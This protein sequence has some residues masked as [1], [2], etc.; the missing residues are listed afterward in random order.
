MTVGTPFSWS[1]LMVALISAIGASSLP[2]DDSRGAK[3]YAEKCAS[4]HGAEGEGV[5][6]KYAQPLIG[7]RSLAELTEYVAETMPEDKPGTCTGEDAQQVSAYL[8]DAFYSPIAQARNRPA[9]IDLSR[10]TVRQHRLA[11]AD[12]IGSFRW[13]AKQDERHGL[14][15][16]YYKA[17]RF[18]KENRII[19]RIDPQVRFD[20]GDKSPEEGKIEPHEFS[21]RWNGTIT[22]PE[23]GQYEIIVR[24]EHA[25]RL[26]LNDMKE[27]IVD[28]W[29]KSGND[30][31]Y[32]ASLFLLGGRMYPIRLEF[33]KAKQGVDDSDKD[34][35]PKLVPASVALLWKRPKM[36][37]EVIASR[38]LAPGNAPESF[39]L[40]T[41]FPPDDRSAGYERAASVSREWDQATTEAA[42]E[43]ANY[44]V[45]HI[46][47]FSATK[48]DSGD[49]DVKLKE[50][51]AKFA[52][53]AFRRPL[54]D[55]ERKLY[56]DQI[57]SEAGNP[58]LGVR[59]VVL[60]TMKSPRFLFREVE[61]HGDSWDV[62]SR[63]SFALWDSI[64]DQQLREVA[65][66]DQLKDE[67]QI[68][69]QAE[70]MV[71]DPRANAKLTEFFLRWLKVEQHPDL[72]KDAE[73]YVGFNAE[74]ACDLRSSLEI[75]LAD[76]LANEN[77]DLRELLKTHD[78][79]FNGR[80]AKFYGADL[81]EDA[82]FQRVSLQADDGAGIL[83]HPYLMAG[84]AYTA[85]SSPIHRGVFVARSLLGRSLRPPPEAVA[86][87]APDLHAGLT[88]RERVTL[89]TSP[90]A[91]QTCH[92]LINPLGFSFEHFDAVGRYRKEENGK[93]IDAKGTYRARSGDPIPMD[94]ANG[95]S[96][97]LAGSDEV[98]T[99]FVDQLFQYAV[100]QPIR[101][102]GS[103]TRNGLKANF[104]ENNLN[105]RKLFVQIAAAAAV[106]A[107][108]PKADASNPK[109]T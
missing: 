85:T 2:A 96:A 97:F 100:K 79:Y 38:F 48:R 59:R 21:I 17:R 62:A 43:T 28:A 68:L 61:Q 53:R 44:V 27:P 32:K 71:R 98:H 84:F 70:R 60:L 65:S 66:K 73:K 83:T 29:V 51:C 75:T 5:K 102:Y 52:E 90:Q 64:P 9:R 24:T 92:N 6:D 3:I 63:L 40:N 1:L 16:E 104:V 107:A 36:E 77:C 106:Q 26:W 94:G 55:D 82:E 23:T 99:A 81:P 31:E 37:P 14:N 19:E 105:V 12:L 87:L 91:C 39:I 25:A 41:P 93:P 69:A 103:E 54:T 89:Q 57:Y 109:G 74:I 10:L 4:C 8:Y 33:S 56:I 78:I 47:E 11:L 30:V 46:S 88:T 7:D 45:D 101:A 72:T 35:K 20:F 13:N 108:N 34:K 42:I 49:R 80:L 76:F 50:F 15:G 18:N 67:K 22:P 86:P 58:D 95:I